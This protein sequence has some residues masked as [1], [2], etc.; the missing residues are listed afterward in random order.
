[1][2]KLLEMILASDE[3]DLDTLVEKLAKGIEKLEKV[4]G[5]IEFHIGKLDGKN[6]AV[7]MVGNPIDIAF[8]LS[9]GVSYFLK[10]VSDEDKRI[11][12]FKTMFEYIE[13]EI[14]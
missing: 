14:K 11:S 5:D 7:S 2:E 6:M 10:Q 12:L 9:K 8:H 13:M 3:K 4:P 1:M